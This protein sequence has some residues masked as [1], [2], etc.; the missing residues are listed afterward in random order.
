MGLFDDIKGALFQTAE[1]EA[2][3]LI[4]GAVEKAVPGG[5]GGLL[6]KLQAGGLGEQVQSWLGDG[7][8]LPISPDQLQGVLGDEHVQ[9]IA[10]H[11][12]LD[13]QQVLQGLSEHLP[14]LAAKQAES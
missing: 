11:L 14:G 9:Q 7:H 10:Q 3:G 6:G 8:N 4:G 13:P 12:G 1:G 2:Q 5:L